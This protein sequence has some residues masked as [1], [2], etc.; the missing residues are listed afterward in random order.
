[1][2]HRDISTHTLKMATQYPVIT[3]TGPRQSGKTTLV[4]ELFKNKP[5][6]SLENIDQME[7]AETD[8]RG[9]LASFPNGVVI[10][11]VQ[12]VP[13]LFSYVQGIVDEQKQNGMF[14]LTGS[15]QFALMR[16]ITQSLAGRTAIIE[17]LPF[18]INEIK[19]SYEIESIDELL[20][21]GFYPRIYD[22]S[23][24]P[25]QALEF[26]FRTYVERDLREISQIH[27]LSLFQ[28]FVRMCAGRTGQLLNLSSLANSVGVTHT[29]A[30]EWIS[31]LEASYIIFLLEPYAINIKKRLVKS[32]KLYFYD[33]G[34]AT[35]LM[36]IGQ[37]DQLSTHPLRGNL[38]E[39]LVIMEILKY[40]YN[41]GKSNNLNFYRDHKGNEVD[42]IYNIAQHTLPLEVKSGQTVTK[43][44]FRGLN[45][46]EK[47]F[48][49]LP[50]GKAIVYGGDSY[51]Q[52]LE[53][54]ILNPFK[55]YN[56]LK[57][58]EI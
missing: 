47:L 55:I 7:R 51:H 31:L 10:D 58:K 54:Q 20:F 16:S 13:S 56:Y 14:V 48:T 4:K 5:Y 9:F 44:Y 1:M 29:T 39:N 45:Q 2:I 19:D 34:L 40:R 33:T 35:H 28:R 11:E 37:Q 17:L 53:T 41:D 46:F 15:Y 26:Y 6:V 32:P 23:L 42:I 22:Q 3:I 27:N 24:D 38:F 25:Y 36:G 50:Y 18:S 57:E 52:Q 8:P 43:D 49:E 30:R 21:K 12:R